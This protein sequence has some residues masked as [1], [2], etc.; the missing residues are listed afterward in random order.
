MC[1]NKTNLF[2]MIKERAKMLEKI[3]DNIEKREI[4]IA[5]LKGKNWFITEAAPSYKESYTKQ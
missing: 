3:E 4:R 5:K 1:L 2:D